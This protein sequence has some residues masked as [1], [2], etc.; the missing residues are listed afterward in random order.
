[1]LCRLSCKIITRSG[2]F[3]GAPATG[4]TIIVNAMNFYRLSDDQIIEEIEQPDM[5]QLT[6]FSRIRRNKFIFQ[7]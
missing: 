6:I 1:M 5:L 2:S 4:K 7:E 3:F